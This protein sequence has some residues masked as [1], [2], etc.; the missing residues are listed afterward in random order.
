MSQYFKPVTSAKMISLCP[1]ISLCTTGL[2]VHPRWRYLYYYWYL[3]LKERYRQLKLIK[4]F[5]WR[6]RLI[7]QSRGRDG[8]TMSEGMETTKQPDLEK[9]MAQLMC[10]ISLCS[11]FQRRTHQNVHR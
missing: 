10:E 3:T 9:V 11:C 5:G 6:A 1:G 7:L 2:T 8:C 4:L